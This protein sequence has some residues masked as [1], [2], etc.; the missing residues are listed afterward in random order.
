LQEGL[1][2]KLAKIREGRWMAKKEMV[3][4]IIDKAIIQ[5][6][7]DTE[8]LQRK[9]IIKKARKLCNKRE[10]NISKRVEARQKEPK[11]Y[12]IRVSSGIY[13]LNPEFN[14]IFG[15]EP[16]LSEAKDIA[17]SSEGREAHTLVL[18]EA[19]ENWINNFPNPP[20]LEN[21]YLRLVEKCEDHLWFSDLCNHLPASGFDV[22]EKWQKYKKDVQDLDKF[23]RDL[24]KMMEQDISKIF[25]GLELRFVENYNSL[26]SDCQC[27]LPHLILRRAIEREVLDLN[28]SM[29][30]EDAETKEKYE[31]IMDD[32]N[33]ALSNLAYDEELIKEMPL[34]EKGNSLLWGFEPENWPPSI[35]ILRLPKRD[36]EAFMRGKDQAISYF[37]HPPSEIRNKVSELGRELKRLGQER[38]NMLKELKRL[39]YCQC[40]SGDCRYLGR[41]S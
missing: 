37:I 34:I 12:L 22:L 10:A 14:F 30:L 38:E 32:I 33:G 15:R 2:R 11:N 7:G 8:N 19:I 16:L 27:S 23:E 26:E 18:K 28:D 9:T 25:D 35:Q 20:H 41:S 24:S 4:D 3:Y 40:F 6:F 29:R 39:L 5:C 36:K 17:I 21:A 13:K 31:E 1:S